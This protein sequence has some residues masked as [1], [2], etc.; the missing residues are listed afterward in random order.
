MPRLRFVKSR[1]AAF[2]VRPAGRGSTVCLLAALCCAAPMAAQATDTLYQDLAELSLEQLGAVEVTS[3]S[4]RSERLADA[5]ASVYVITADDIQRY[6][7][8]TLPEALRLAPNLLVAQINAN[9]YAISSRGMNSSTANKLQVLIDGRIVYTPLYSGVFW[10]AQDVMLD[11]VDRIEVISGPGSALWGANAVNGVIN[12]ITKPATRTL[13]TLAY[14]GGGNAQ[15]GIGAR[16]GGSAGDERSFRIYAKAQDFSS[17]S[18]GSAARDGWRRSQAGFRVDFGQGSDTATLQGDIYENSIEQR[19]ADRQKHSGANLLARMTR[20]LE[21][22]SSL[23]LQAY[24]DRTERDAPSSYGDRLDTVNLEF[25]YSLPEQAGQQF[26]WGGGYRYAQD[27]VENKSS[28]F[29][30]LPA[31]TRLH[32]V[33]LFAQWERRLSPDWR[34]ILGGRVEDNN[35]TGLEFMPSARLSWRL[36]EHR[37]VWASLSRSVRTPSRLDREFYIPASP[38][39]SLA[40]GP[41][42]ESEVAKTFELGYRGQ[43]GAHASYSVT[44]FHTRYNKIRSLSTL[45]G[46]TV[47]LGNEIDGTVQGVEAWGSYRLSDKWQLS[48]GGL[49]LHESFGG[50]GVALTPPG[51]DPRSQL[52]LRGTWVPAENHEL[53]LMAR[54]VGRLRTPAVDAYTAVDA[55]YGWRITKTTQLSLLVTNLFDRHHGEFSGSSGSVVQVGRAAYLQVKVAY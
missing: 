36:D 22:G 6:G 8:T 52:F 24:F 11:D 4:R 46:G 55:R 43:S 14:A 12:V 31:T 49:L 7:A 32:W 53:S 54:Y 44:G 42:F 30:F 38:P 23:F 33:N 9:Q 26:V 18:F 20:K 27:E 21:G 10:D 35:Y 2:L 13:G 3:V 48:G 50:V 17:S 15:R 47:V 34:L 51:N 45:P 5:A 19:A 1:V 37:Q 39:Y 40:G 28:A 25:Q 16:Y 29:A 41:G